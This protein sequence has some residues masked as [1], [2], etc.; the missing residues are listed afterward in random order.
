MAGSEAGAAD[1]RRALEGPLTA[2]SVAL[3]VE[4]GQEPAVQQRWS[5]ALRDPRAPVRAAAAR[6][7]YASRTR[8]L[9]AELSQAL[10]DETDPTAADEEL[11]AVAHLDRNRGPEPP[12]AGGRVPDARPP[13]SALGDLP[14][15]LG[16]DTFSAAGCDLADG[17]GW[18]AANVDYGSDG[19]PQGVSVWETVTGGCLEAARALFLLALPPREPWPRSD[20]VVIALDPEV[21]DCASPG[22]RASPARAVR[23]GDG[24]VEPK[25]LHDVKPV[26]PEQAKQERIQ[27]LVILEGTI[28]T[29]G[30]IQALRLIKSA[31]PSLDLAALLA[32]LRW[33]YA[34]TLLGGVPV[35][36]MMTIT[37]NFRLS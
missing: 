14:P 32:V 15:G 5:Q 13:L 24:I 20:I 22:S 31:H 23:V 35:P 3:L 19:R 2:G 10:A 30:C 26:Y 27:G 7:V 6:A 34:P 11:H 17:R 25:K 1:W 18:A 21:L 8:E 12:G 9:A 37:V 36:V 33:R 4:H 29:T 28:S 16:T